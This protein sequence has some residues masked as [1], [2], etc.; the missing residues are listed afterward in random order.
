MLSFPLLALLISVANAAIEPSSSG[1]IG[2]NVVDIDSK[3]TPA[4][5]AV[6]IAVATATVAA[7]GYQVGDVSAVFSDVLVEKLKGLAQTAC[8]GGA[9]LRRRQT[10]SISGAGSFVEAAAGPGG[11]MNDILINGLPKITIAA[12][13]VA[14]ALQAMV[15]AGKISAASVPVGYLATIWLSAYL[16]KGARQVVKIPKADIDTGSGNEPNEPDKPT[17]AS[18]TSTSTPCPTGAEAVS[19]FAVPE[20]SP[21]INTQP[22]CADLVNCGGVMNTICIAGKY[23][24]CKCIGEF[25]ITL[26][27]GSQAV[28]DDQQSYLNA[29]ELAAAAPGGPSPTQAP[30]C[31]WNADKAA[32]PTAWCDCAGGS[33]T[34]AI[35]TGTGAA[36]CPYTTAPG[37]TISVATNPGGGG[38][39]SSSAPPKPAPTAVQPVQCNTDAQYVGADVGKMRDLV[40]RVCGAVGKDKGVPYFSTLPVCSEKFA[41]DVWVEYKVLYDQ[42]APKSQCTWPQLGTVSFDDCRMAMT[43]SILCESLSLSVA[44]FARR[45]FVVVFFSTTVDRT[46]SES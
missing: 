34:F 13:D 25:E 24:L 11:P 36:A 38:K 43:D 16:E 26:H 21:L 35:A 44:V 6:Q 3:P 17:A 20:W 18:S 30:W 9:K 2:I 29:L 8:G 46:T 32:T 10:C 37:P 7:D 31:I 4:V 28:L 45:P 1:Q 27:D 15:A 23:K 12:S 22:V 5:T 19:L 42:A 33:S 41:D 39:P 14:K 40:D